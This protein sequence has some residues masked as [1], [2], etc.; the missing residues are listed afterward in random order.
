MNDINNEKQLASAMKREYIDALLALAEEF[1]AAYRINLADGTMECLSQSDI[2]C[3]TSKVG[4]ITGY[5]DTI[6]DYVDGRTL[7]YASVFPVARWTSPLWRN[8]IC[9]G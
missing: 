6:K 4:E 1:A 5:E 2:L 9:R 7:L 3:N 8:E